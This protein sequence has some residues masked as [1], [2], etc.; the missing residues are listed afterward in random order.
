MPEIS[1]VSQGV[2]LFKFKVYTVAFACLH[3]SEMSMKTVKG[4]ANFNAYL[5]VSPSEEKCLT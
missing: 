2:A 3:G 4:Q 5:N 1:N